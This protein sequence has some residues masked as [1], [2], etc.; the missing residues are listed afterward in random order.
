MTATID[1]TE[2]YFKQFLV[3]IASRIAPDRK[4]HLVAHSMGNRAL[5]RVISKGL[6]EVSEEGQ[7]KFGQI[8]LAA[9]DV[10]RDLFAQLAP[11]YPQMSDRTTVYLSPYD[12]AVRQSDR[13]HDYPRVG[14]GTAPQVVV[15]G[16][17]NVVSTLKEDLPAHAYFAENLPVLRDIKNLILRNE[18]ARSTKIWEKKDGYWIVGGAPI[19][20]KVR[21]WTD[22]AAT[23]SIVK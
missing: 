7:I 14:C 8:I 5:L 15:P 2:I 23:A 19:P 17:D 16:I 1:A 20:K 4:V 9:A 12:F 6:E 13:I 10:D 22:Q 3:E 11:S 21:C 18:P